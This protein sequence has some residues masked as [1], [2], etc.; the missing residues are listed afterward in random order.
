MTRSVTQTEVTH[1][2][3]Q[4]KR[5]AAVLE[6]AR[7]HRQFL[8]REQDVVMRDSPGTRTRRGVYMSADGDRPTKVLDATMHEVPAGVTSTV[9]RHSWDARSPQRLPDGPLGGAAAAGRP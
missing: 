3:I 9:D 1:Y 2:E 6:E 4:K 7:K 8:I 5:R